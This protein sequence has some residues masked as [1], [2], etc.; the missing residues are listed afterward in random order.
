[1]RSLRHGPKHQI[2]NTSAEQYP[3][4]A[5]GCFIDGY[6]ALIGRQLAP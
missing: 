6:S 3:S 1:M 2:G 5:I 4:Q